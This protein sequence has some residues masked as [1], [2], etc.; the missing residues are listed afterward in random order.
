MDDEAKQQRIKAKVNDLKRELFAGSVVLEVLEQGAEYPDELTADEL[1]GIM[2]KLWR[3]WHGWSQPELAK[4]SGV[5]VETISRLEH[6]QRQ[7]QHSTIGA[8]ARALKVD[9]INLDPGSVFG[10]WRRYLDE[11]NE[12]ERALQRLQEA[13][14]GKVKA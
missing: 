13:E 7:A 10:I 14:R 8:L 2:I 6:G 3:M 4:R 5:R 12:R 9:P 11:Q 1:R